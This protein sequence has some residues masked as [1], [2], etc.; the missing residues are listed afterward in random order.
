MQVEIWSDIAC[1]FCYIGKRN[2]ETALAAFDHAEDVEVI[3]HSFQLAPDLPREVEGNMH[4]Y[5]AQIKG[6]SYEDAVALNDR[7]VQMGAEAGLEYNFDIAR[8]A[9]T[10]DAHRL[11]HLA[12][13]LGLAPELKER[14]LR[15]YFAEGAN[16]GDTD[17]LA[18]LAVEVGIPRSEAVDVLLTHR[19]A[20]D[21][22]ADRD[23]ATQLGIHAVP[24]F[25][26]DRKFGLSGAQPPEAFSAALEQGWADSAP[27]IQLATND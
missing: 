9:N 17:Q 13:S 24:F 21:V 8:V 27:L 5:L 22:R 15:A 12:K 19:F 11:L 16:F 26:I 25:V 20:D 23:E 10:F 2:F 7:V 3:W 18:D 14:M 6:V 4:S 1:P